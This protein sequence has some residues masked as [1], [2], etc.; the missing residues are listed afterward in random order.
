MINFLNSIVRKTHFSLVI[1]LFRMLQNQWGGG[2][3]STFYYCFTI[4][5][6][7]EKMFDVYISSLMSYFYP[8]YNFV[9][10]N[11]YSTNLHKIQ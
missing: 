9:F 10:Y 4:L 6:N 2:F 3:T 1:F 7:S 8:L 5:T 11:I